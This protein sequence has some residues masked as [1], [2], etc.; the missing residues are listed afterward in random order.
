MKIHCFRSVLL[1]AA[2]GIVV[3]AW[4]PVRAGDL[5][6][7]L[8][9]AV[10]I[11]M[12]GAVE[13]WDEDGKPRFPVDPKAKI[14]EPRVDARAVRQ[15]SGKWIFRNPPINTAAGSRTAAA[16]CSTV[17]SW[18]GANSIAGPGSGSPGS[19]ESKWARSPQP[20]RVSC[21]RN[22]ILG[23]PEAG[24]R[25][26]PARVDRCARHESEIRRERDRRDPGSVCSLP[27]H[28][29]PGLPSPV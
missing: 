20:S 22:T 2:A 29:S 17:S 12:V 10:D 24:F 8:G 3:S 19:V 14:A 1:I 23:M 6:V 21:P 25:T 27:L 15:G 18:P 9:K 4:S 13:R 7:D 11:S 26:E 5:V 28:G 16:K